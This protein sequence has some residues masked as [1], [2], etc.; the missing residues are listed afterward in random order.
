M[1]PAL[2]AQ[3]PRRT[4]LIWMLAH[5]CAIEQ[6]A[7]ARFEHF[8]RRSPGHATPRESDRRFRDRGILTQER[9]AVKSGARSRCRAPHQ[10]GTK[11]KGFKPKASNQRLQTPT[12]HNHTNTSNPSRPARGP[13]PRIV[14]STLATLA[15]SSAGDASFRM[16]SVARCLFSASESWAD[17][18]RA[19]SS[20]DQPRVRATRSCRIADGASTN[21]TASHS[22]SRPTSRRSGASMTKATFDSSAAANCARRSASMRGCM[23]RSTRWRASADAKMARARS[24]RSIEASGASNDEAPVGGSTI[25][26]ICAMTSGSANTRRARSSLL[27]TSQP[28]AANARATSLLPLPIPPTMPM[29]GRNGYLYEVI[30]DRIRIRCAHC[31]RLCRAPAN[32]DIHIRQTKAHVNRVTVL[33]ARVRCDACEV[34]EMR[35]PRLPSVPRLRAAR[36]AAHRRSKRP[37]RFHQVGRELGPFQHQGAPNRD[38]RR[39]PKQAASSVCGVARL[40][41][42][43]CHQTAAALKRETTRVFGCHAGGQ[44]RSPRELRATLLPRDDVFQASDPTLAARQRVPLLRCA[45]LHA[46][47]AARDARASVSPAPTRR[48]PH[49]HFPRR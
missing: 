33:R 8:D 35:A 13:R 30:C 29:V 16:T 21:T 20:V 23:M 48:L 7:R 4:T 47:N 38:L 40:H 15:E 31:C 5:S 49:D 14:S 12:R 6:F 34:E 24:A 2:W 36:G 3:F 39:V 44:G 11:P 32:R 18:R 27:Q 46:L 22:R 37:K 10:Q 26:V 9:R 1:E 17:S 43:L 28:S 42:A 45:W 41:S 25:D 19:S